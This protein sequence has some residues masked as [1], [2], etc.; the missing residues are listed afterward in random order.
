MSSFSLSPIPVICNC[1]ENWKMSSLN[2]N[3]KCYMSTKGS[4]INIILLVKTQCLLTGQKRYW[5]KQQWQLYVINFLNLKLFAHKVVLLFFWSH[6]LILFYWSK[7]NVYLLVKNVTGQ[8]NNDNHLL[9]TFKFLLM[10]MKFW[11]L[12][13]F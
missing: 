1:H 6:I 13:S 5:T 11:K 3:W 8:N 12:C 7:L 10:K 4:D 9:S 2:L